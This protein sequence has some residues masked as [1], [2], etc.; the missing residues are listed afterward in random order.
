MV[1]VNELRAQAAIEREAIG[2]NDVQEP[3]AITRQKPKPMAEEAYHGIAGDI[4]EA[5]A[6]HTE[7][8]REALLI[9]ALA[10]LGNAVGR[11]RLRS[12][13]PGDVWRRHNG[14]H[15]HSGV[16]DHPDLVRHR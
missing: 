10:Q 14:G 16:Y 9:D 15:L 5:I 12:G 11:G 13:H 8:Y 3:K 7:A 6:P 1:S 4:V 2:H